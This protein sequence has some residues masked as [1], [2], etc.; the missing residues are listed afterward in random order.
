MVVTDD[1]DTSAPVASP[2]EPAA[3]EIVA[4]AVLEE[5]HVTI[6]VRLAVAPL[7]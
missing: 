3:L 1:D 2:L 7:S 5:V 4:A 6:P